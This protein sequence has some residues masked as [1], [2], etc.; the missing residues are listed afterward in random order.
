[1]KSTIMAAVFIRFIN[2]QIFSKISNTDVNKTT[3]N[4]VLV[5]LEVFY[6]GDYEECRLLGCGALQILC[7]PT[8]FKVEKS[9][10]EETA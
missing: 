9:A 3:N 7:E 10:G 6:G 5:R 2:L 8:I 1:M 4:N